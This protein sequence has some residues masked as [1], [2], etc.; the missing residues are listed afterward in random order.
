M[1]NQDRAQERVLALSAAI[2]N[3]PYLFAESGAPADALAASCTRRINGSGLAS[4]CSG[5]VAPQAVSCIL[6]SE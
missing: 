5:C 2:E 6:S 3:A 1:S 4:S